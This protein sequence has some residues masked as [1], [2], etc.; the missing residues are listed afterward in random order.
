MMGNQKN[1][2]RGRF[3]WLTLLEIKLFDGG[4]RK[5]ADVT[6]S[7]ELDDNGDDGVG[8]SDDD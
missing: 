3:F 4:K 2:P 1:L 7:K 5:T 6:E 8:G